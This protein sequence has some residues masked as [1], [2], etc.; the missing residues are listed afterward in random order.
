ME[1]YSTW[2]ESTSILELFMR[3]MSGLFNENGQDCPYNEIGCKYKH[4]EKETDNS[5]DKNDDHY[6]YYCRQI[7]LSGHRYNQNIQGEYIK[8]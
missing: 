5:G 6:Y 8:L 1:K 3:S 2:N 4:I 7:Y